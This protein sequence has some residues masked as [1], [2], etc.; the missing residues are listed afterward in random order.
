MEKM[1]TDLNTVWKYVCNGSW[2]NSGRIP[3]ANQNA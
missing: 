2:K 1:K 3:R